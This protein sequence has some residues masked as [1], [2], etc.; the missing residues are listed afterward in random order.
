MPGSPSA[1]GPVVLGSDVWVGSGAAILSG[2]TVGHGAV[3]GARAV[4]T[5]DVPPFGVVVGNPAR[6]VKI[7]FGEA[8]VA[9]LLAV[10]WWRWERGRVDRLVPLLISGDIEAFLAA[11]EASA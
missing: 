4:V 1:K 3:V 7:R 5:K 10:A 8:T 11:A 9:R 2:V 6:L